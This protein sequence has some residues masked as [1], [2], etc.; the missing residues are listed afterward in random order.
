M[1]SVHDH[2]LK[3]KKELELL[4]E[5]KENLNKERQRSVEAARKLDYEV[6]K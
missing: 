5:Q 2:N 1:H 3:I 6:V 4:Q